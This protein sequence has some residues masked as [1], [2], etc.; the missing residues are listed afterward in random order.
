FRQGES[1]PRHNPEFT[2]VEW[3]RRGDDYDAGMRLLSD[4]C[5]ATLGRGA[6]ERITYR[7]AFVRHAG[8]DPL[9]ASVAELEQ[10][11][12]SQD[13]LPPE[14]FNREDRDVWLDWLLVELVEPHLGQSAPTILHDYPPSQAALAIVRDDNPQVAERFELY[15]AGIE[16]AN[17]Y[18]ELLD[19]DVLR[20]RNRANNALRREDGKRELPEDSRLLAAMGAGLPPCTGVALG[21]DRLVMLAAGATDIRDVIAFPIDRA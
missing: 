17:G 16:L 21:F 12:R 1:G 2:I 11:G 20:Q 8:V 7:E 15:V 14:S 18:H 9:V 5:E 19:A 6:A 10:A 3:Y 13:L 4:L